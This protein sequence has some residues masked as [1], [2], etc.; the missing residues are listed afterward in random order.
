MRRSDV[1]DTISQLPYKFNTPKTYPLGD[2]LDSYSVRNVGKKV[3]SSQSINWKGVSNSSP[4]TSIPL[5]PVAG[6]TEYVKPRTAR[7]P[8]PWH[9]SCAGWHRAPSSCCRRTTRRRW[10]GGWTRCAR[11]RRRPRRAATRCRRPTPSPNAAPSSRSRRS[12]FSPSPSCSRPSCMLARAGRT[13]VLMIPIGT[14]LVVRPCGLAPG[15][16][17]RSFTT[18]L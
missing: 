15:D 4:Q 7:T 16:R 10:R 8:R 17:C 2:E 12:Q 3:N 13:F 6:R 1:S 14:P 5:S 18:S 11:A 9:D